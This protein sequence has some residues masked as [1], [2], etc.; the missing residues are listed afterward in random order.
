MAILLL[1]AL[2][3]PAVIT[4]QD[5][6]RKAPPTGVFY[7]AQSLQLA[8]SVQAECTPEAIEAKSTEV[9]TINV[10]IN[11]QGEPVL[12]EVREFPG[13]G[14]G[15]KALQAVSQWRWQPLPDRFPPGVERIEAGVLMSCQC[16]AT[17]P[18]AAD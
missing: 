10:E 2:L 8:R 11:R 3:A 1:G 7:K 17:T 5:A 6:A 4:A 15:P 9:V 13:Y 18:R 16:E 14:L 12:L